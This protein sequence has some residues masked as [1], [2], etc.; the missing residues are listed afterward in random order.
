[1]MF[2]PECH[3]GTSINYTAGA[4]FRCAQCHEKLASDGESA[5]TV[6][7][8]EQK[9]PIVAPV[10]VANHPQTVDLLSQ[11]RVPPGPLALLSRPRLSPDFIS[12][13]R[14]LRQ[15]Q[16]LVSEHVG[17]YLD[18]ILSDDVTECLP[19]EVGMQ[20]TQCRQDGQIRRLEVWREGV[21]YDIT[22]SPVSLDRTRQW[23]AEQSPDD[24]AYL[25]FLGW[26]VSGDRRPDETIAQEPFALVHIIYS[27]GKWGGKWARLSFLPVKPDASMLGTLVIAE[28]LL[29][30][31]ERASVDAWFEE[32]RA[33]CQMRSRV[34]V[35]CRPAGTRC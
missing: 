9:Y 29:A 20:V 24:R 34:P 6:E 7:A 26:R 32:V 11:P 17:S 23:F 18:R 14:E 25:G 4:T 35:S 21:T 30:E 31:G 12:S 5:L 33:A 13:V 2:C 8:F 10:R 3:A 16:G 15:D 1:M 28:D 19:R 27:E 22:I